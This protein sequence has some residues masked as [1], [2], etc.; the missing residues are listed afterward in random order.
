MITHVVTVKDSYDPVRQSISIARSD[1]IQNGDLMIAGIVEPRGDLATI[2]APAGWTRLR[3]V[4]ALTAA[5]DGVALT[6]YYR[7][8]ENETDRWTW[9]FAGQPPSFFVGIIGVYR[10]V[11]YHVPIDVVDA[12]FGT[13]GLS[14]SAPAVTTADANERLIA[15]F[16]ANT[17]T[18]FSSSGCAIRDSRASAPISDASAL[19]AS[20]GIG[21]TLQ[22]AT[23]YGAA[24]SATITGGVPS[25]WIGLTIGVRPDTYTVSTDET[26]REIQNLFPPGSEDL[27]DWDSAAANVYKKT[28]ADAE[29]IKRYGHDLRDLVEREA[30]PNRAILKLPDWE[31]ALGISEAVRSQRGAD[32]TARR[33]FLVTEKLRESGTPTKHKI[34]AALEPLL[35]YTDTGNEGTLAILETNRY[36]LRAAHT[37]SDDTSVTIAAAGSGNKTIA[38]LDDGYVS[39]AGV[40][41][42]IQ[43]TALDPETVSFS[44]TGPAASAST[45]QTGTITTFTAE[46]LVTGSGTRFTAAIAPGMQVTGDAGATWHTVES[47]QNDT[48]LT[49]RA[50]AGQNLSG[51]AYSSRTGQATTTWA[52]GV[53]P[54]GSVEREWFRLSAITNVARRTIHGNWTFTINAGVVSEVSVHHAR[55]F[56]E[57]SGRDSLGND[58]LAS[59]I[60]YWCAVVEEDK[61][62]SG[63]TPDWVAFGKAVDR[64]THAHA[65]GFYVRVPTTIPLYGYGAIPSATV[66]SPY[67]VPGFC[68]PSFGA[69][70]PWA[71]SDTA[72]DVAIAAR[73]RNEGRTANHP[74]HEGWFAYVRLP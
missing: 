22:A 17:S 68:I 21:D 33:Q 36:K 48:L 63:F 25:T 43:I 32:S 46:R 73:S 2:T 11:D 57:A 4:R 53:L 34:R 24:I 18:G 66:T 16:A 41:I 8:A 7:F 51:A 27:W 40:Q 47:V 29:F 74:A 42:E 50:A 6:V 49:L 65:I 12:T 39:A 20:V 59:G 13:A 26:K 38:V 9:S 64:L 15:L 70:M 14:A 71:S 37:R 19:L 54:V 72:S 58:G 52:A 44:L 3:N 23:G 30:V 35:G 28:L 69:F 56:V 5:N 67:S 1:Y 31:A 45:V 55:L 62:P 60:H 10:G 61:L